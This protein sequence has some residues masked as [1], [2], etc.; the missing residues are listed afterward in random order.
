MFNKIL[1]HGI[2]YSI[3]CISVIFQ[4]PLKTI[5]SF[6]G[7]PRRK[8]SR[9]TILVNFSKIQRHLPKGIPIISLRW[10]DDFIMFMILQCEYL[11]QQHG[12]FLVNK[13]PV[14]YA[15]IVNSEC[16]QD[17]ASIYAPY[18]SGER[19]RI[20]W[21]CWNGSI[22]WRKKKWWPHCVCNLTGWLL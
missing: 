6:L 16:Q 15:F 2:G 3:K 8:I 13:G 11:Y 17:K 22:F 5:S 4:R 19:C 21:M 7:V 18:L 12:V 1:I 9:D 14:L 20:T 10:S